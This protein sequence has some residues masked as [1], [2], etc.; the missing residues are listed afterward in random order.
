MDCLFDPKS[1]IAKF[2]SNSHAR[3]QQVAAT[4][5]Q[6]VTNYDVLDFDVNDL[7]FLHY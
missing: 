4:L 7:L 6:S 3:Q 5:F 2:G 1:I